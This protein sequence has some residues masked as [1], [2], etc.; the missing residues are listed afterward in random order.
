MFAFRLIMTTWDAESAVDFLNALV[1]HNEA[2]LRRG[3]AEKRERP[4]LYD[5]QAVYQAE[6]PGA[7]DMQDVD[8][9]I[10]LGRGDC[11]DLATYRAAYINVYGSKAFPAD[12]PLALARDIR[13]VVYL[14]D[15]NG[16][17]YHCMVEIFADGVRSTEDPSAMLGMH[18]RVD[19]GVLRR[20]SSRRPSVRRLET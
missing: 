5:T 16:S 4:D 19:P 3:I 17:D 9:V 7:E 8:Q 18:G 20:R 13:A 10:A 1:R 12:H 6:P 11:E 15:H 14:R 2:V